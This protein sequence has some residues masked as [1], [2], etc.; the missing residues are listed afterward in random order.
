M[1]TALVKVVTVARLRLEERLQLYR[2]VPDTF[3]LLQDKLLGM[4][5]DPYQTVC[6]KLAGIILPRHLNDWMT[7]TAKYNP[8]HLHSVLSCL[9]KVCVTFRHLLERSPPIPMLHC[10]M[11]LYSVYWMCLCGYLTTLEVLI[12][13]VSYQ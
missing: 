7:D 3:P 5:I 1:E 8:Q 10:R 2:T 9:T 11:K 4:I 12:A 13:L 6:E